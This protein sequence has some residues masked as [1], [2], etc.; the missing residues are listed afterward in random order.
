MSDDSDF[1]SFAFE[2]WYY[3]MF[4]DDG[5]IRLAFNMSLSIYR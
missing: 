3:I 2:T 5:H 1:L 4:A